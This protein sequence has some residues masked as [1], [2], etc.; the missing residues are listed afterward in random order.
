[1]Q[2]RWISSELVFNTEKL[3]VYDYDHIGLQLSLML[4]PTNTVD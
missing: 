1:M 3:N 4:K 2:K